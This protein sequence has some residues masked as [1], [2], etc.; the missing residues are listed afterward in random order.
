MDDHEKG[1]NEVLGTKE[2]QDAYPMKEVSEDLVPDNL[3]VP[4]PIPFAAWLIIVTELC[5]RFS[6]YGASML[7][8][9]YMLTHLDLTKGSATAISRGFSFF[10]YITT[11]FGAI[12]ADKWLGKYKT[13]LIFAILYTLGLVLLTVSSID[14]LKDTVGLPGF[15]VAL[16]CAISWGTGGIKSNV[17]TFAAEQIPAED[18]PHPTK[19]GVTINH[20]ITVERVFRYFYMAIN[21]GGMLGQAITPAV[22]EKGWDLAFMIPAIVF[23][24]GIIIFALGRSKYYDRPPKGNVLGETSR[25]LIYAFKHRKERVPGTHWIQGAAPKTD[26]SL[27]W[28]TKFVDDLER[29]Y[30][31]CKVFLVYPVYWALYN[32]MNDNFVN[33][34]INMQRPSWL[35]PEQLSFVN[36]AVIV[37][38]IP[39][40]DIVIFPFLRK[41][42]FKLGPINRIIIGF[43]IVTFCFIYV[44]VLQ[45]FLYKAGPYY[46]FTGKDPHNPGVVI[47]IPSDISL[48]INDITI[49]TQ[50][51]AYI[52]IGISEIFASATGL[53]FA[54]RSAAPEL[55]SVVMSLFLATNAFGSLI[56]MIL[57]IWSNDPNF[58]YVY[59]AQAAAMFVMTGLFA[60]KFAHL[61]NII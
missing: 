16:Y 49:W 10:S 30:H 13:I 24:I 38:F 28:N 34:A 23:V 14:S 46:D 8:Q 37:I 33:M 57:A 51:P 26:D 47:D 61:D 6:F 22:S 55:K 52:L 45:H 43:S 7:F 2:I 42:G 32:N 27:E 5:E 9:R 19:T 48:V 36:S 54:F 15:V 39:I 31:A 1:R 12:V 56:G 11:I 25:C 20:A 17:S 59:A 3:Q 60:W 35:K 58:V 40:L 18:Y 29:T 50:L 4:G 44:T 21:I 41:A 53:E